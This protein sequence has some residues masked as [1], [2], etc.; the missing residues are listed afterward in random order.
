MK[1]WTHVEVTCQTEPIEH[2]PQK[3]NNSLVVVDYSK[4]NSI[5]TKSVSRISVGNWALNG[6]KA[7]KILKQVIVMPEEEKIKVHI[8]SYL[9]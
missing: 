7:L 4:T 3:E 1:I 8:S 2:Y 5:T 6:A 9:L